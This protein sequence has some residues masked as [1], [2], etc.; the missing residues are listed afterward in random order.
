MMKYLYPKQIGFDTKPLKDKLYAFRFTWETTEPIGKPSIKNGFDALLAWWQNTY[1]V[2]ITHTMLGIEEELGVEIAFKPKRDLSVT[3]ETLWDFLDRHAGEYYLNLA[4]P[5][6][7][8]YKP[9]WP[10]WIW[11]LIAGGGIGTTVA[12]VKKRRK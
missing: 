9:R 5:Q 4:L 12:I 6:A 11:V 1:D 8:L 3:M 10:W 2:S 7:I